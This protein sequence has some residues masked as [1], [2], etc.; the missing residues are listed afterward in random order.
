MDNNSLYTHNYA[1][2]VKK[3]GHLYF[4][5]PNQ[6]PKVSES[7]FYLQSIVTPS[8]LLIVEIKGKIMRKLEPNILQII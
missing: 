5:Q 6:F 7:K 3:I 4:A 1:L 8:P 2:L